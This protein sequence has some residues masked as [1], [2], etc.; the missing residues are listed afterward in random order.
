MNQYAPIHMEA[1]PVSTPVLPGLHLEGV[2]GHGPISAADQKARAQSEGARV[3][4]W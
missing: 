2:T 3:F 4:S 1:F